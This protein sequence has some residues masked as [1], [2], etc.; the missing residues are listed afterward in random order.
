MKYHKTK[1]WQT[2][3]VA[4]YI[5]NVNFVKS[6]YKS[7][8]RPSNTEYEQISNFINPIIVYFFPN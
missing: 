6:S 1:N 5:Q 7:L 4:S 2:T 8:R 3:K